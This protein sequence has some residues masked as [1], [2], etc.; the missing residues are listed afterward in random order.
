MSD[1][2]TRLNTLI[3]RLFR[4]PG[5]LERL[6]ADREQLFAEA[7]LSEPQCIALRDGSPDA[8]ESVGLHPI[9]RMHYLM[10]TNPGLADSVSIREFLPGLAKERR[11]G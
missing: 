2:A 7:G 9:L 3:G 4:E 11:D 8:L 6:H 10:A 5:L 1:A